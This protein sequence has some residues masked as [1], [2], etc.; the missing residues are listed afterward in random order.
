VFIAGLREQDFE[1]EVWTQE[2]T[3][4][5]RKPS[6][7]NLQTVSA[8]EQMHS[9]IC[10]VFNFFFASACFDAA[11]NFRGLIPIFLKVLQQSRIYNMQVL[12]RM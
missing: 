6:N 9:S 4:G 1:E 11:G 7:E 10:D 2:V 12:V 8:R 5:W 3:G